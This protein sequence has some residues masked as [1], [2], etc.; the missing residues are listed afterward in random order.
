MLFKPADRA[1]PLTDVGKKTL[2]V[3]DKIFSLGEK[4]SE[5]LSQENINSRYK[6]NI[7]VSDTLPK[8]VTRD[9]LQTAASQK[10]HFVITEGS[11]SITV[12]RKW[13]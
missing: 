9:L 7:S 10:R 4:L 13:P 5:F 2:E 1:I 3:A 11:I 8:L 12:M 6:I